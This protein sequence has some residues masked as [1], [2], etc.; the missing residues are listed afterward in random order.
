MN[1]RIDK[2]LDKVTYDVTK[3]YEWAMDLRSY[4]LEAITEPEPRV[5]YIIRQFKRKMTKGR[6]RNRAFAATRMR[7]YVKTIL[8]DA[9]YIRECRR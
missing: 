1:R 5:E 4:L 6:Y 2:K 8:G 7:H 9:T 3:F